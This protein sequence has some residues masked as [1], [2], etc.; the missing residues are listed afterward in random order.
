MRAI[1]SS[2]TKAEIKVRHLLHSLGYRYRL[3]R[4]DLPG[5]PDIV[6]PGRRKVIFVHGCFWHQ[7]E[8]PACADGRMPKSRLN[9]WVPKLTRNRQRDKENEAAL[10][11][12]GWDVLVVWECE[13]E[14]FPPE[15]LI[16]KLIFFLE[17]E[18]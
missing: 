1:R 18:N 6:F 4:K 16:S 14:K 10:K 5:K 3:N 8:D 12:A 15:E 17:Q 2:G 13:V 7:H 9:Y 11:A